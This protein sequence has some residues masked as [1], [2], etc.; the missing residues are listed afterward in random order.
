MTATQPGTATDSPVIEHARDCAEYL[1]IN[2]SDYVEKHFHTSIENLKDY[3][4]VKLATDLNLFQ[5]CKSLSNET[6]HCHPCQDCKISV[7]CQGEDCDQISYTVCNRCL[8]G[9]PY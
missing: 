9:P 3:Q 2:L 6:R 5:R 4:R 7:D 8:E 1:G